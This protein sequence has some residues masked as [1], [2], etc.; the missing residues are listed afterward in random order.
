MPLSRFRDAGVFDV[1]R[2]L[3]GVTDGETD[4]ATPAEPLDP[5]SIDLMDV[6]ALI[7]AATDRLDS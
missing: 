6:D 5:D 3:A 7:Q 2:R 1:I 4:E